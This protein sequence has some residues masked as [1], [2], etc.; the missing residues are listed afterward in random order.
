MGSYSIGISGLNAAQKALDTIGNNVANAATPGYHRQ[1]INLTPA[2]AKQVGSTL[3]GGG[4]NFSNVTRQIDTFLEQEILRQQSVLEDVSKQTDM[5]TTVQTTFGDLSTGNASLGTAIDDFFNA[6]QSLSLSPSD[7]SIDITAQSKVLSNAEAMVNQFKTL[8]QSLT[9]MENQIKLEAKN[10]VE[11]INTLTGSIADLND[12]I[13]KIEVGG[14]QTNNLC[15]QRDQCISDLSKLVGVETQT[16]DSGIVDVRIGGIA[17]VAGTSATELEI[18]LNG[19]N[20]LGVSAAGTGSYNTVV[21]GGSLGGLLSLG[22]SSIP[23]IHDGLD[24][25]AN[26]LIQKINQC[27]VQGVGSD[28]SFTELTGWSMG[29]ENLADFQPPITD[30]GRVYVRITDESTGTVSR[31][32]ITVNK[33]DTLSDIA[34]KFNAITGID[35]SVESSTLHIGQSSSNYKFDFLPAV[36][37]EPTASNL[38]GTSPP[39]VSV[40]GVYDGT[41]NQTLHL[42]VAGTGSVGNGGL[43]LE[44]KNGDGEVIQ[45]FNIGTGYAAGDKLDLGNG[46]KITLGTGDLNDGNTFDVDVF[47]NT[48]TAGLLSAV[49]LNTFFLG[50]DAS[51]IAVCS[52]IADSPGRIATALGPDM[53]DNTNVERLAGLKDQ[54]IS[55]LNSLT[56]GEFYNQ[57]VTDIGQNIST[58]KM[59]EDSANAMVQQ[60]TNQ[61][62][63]ISGVDINDQA[64]Q[65]L[66]YQQMFQAMAKYL[67]TVQSSL[68]SLMDI[69]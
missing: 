57:M 47:A 22:N 33:S 13:Q 29:N 23:E 3:L 41:E 18:G 64:A 26:E 16:R 2:Y 1:T 68:T 15:D 14:G 6:M 69:I 40:S 36:L 19:N 4:V 8:G 39:E 9:E 43:Q 54:Q 45:T 38:T 27:H 42:T 48:D 34:A 58:A 25:L 24:N 52:D 67:T 7:G 5:L 63:D 65:M 51:N 31:E 11:Q 56:F 66:V 62:S 10:T 35:A 28:G 20:S 17:V 37:P 21:E 53:T 61:Q 44:A 46:I 50:N 12:K 59:Q 60:L 55:G 30:G 32:Y 49:G